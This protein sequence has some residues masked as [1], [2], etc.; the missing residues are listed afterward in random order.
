LTLCI[1]EVFWRVV[2]GAGN[3]GGV[4]GFDMTYLVVKRKKFWRIKQP[5]V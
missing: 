4:V 3:G 1:D 2:C 5:N